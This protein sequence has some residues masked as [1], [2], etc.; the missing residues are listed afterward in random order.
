MSIFVSSLLAIIF[1]TICLMLLIKSDGK[2]HRQ[3]N[4]SLSIHPRLRKAASWLC[5]LPAIVLLWFGFY[6]SVFI[7]L[8]AV[9]VIGWAIAHLPRS[10]A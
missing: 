2:R 6:T 7:W 1:S 5:L 10:I 8:G 4:T 3:D 9:T